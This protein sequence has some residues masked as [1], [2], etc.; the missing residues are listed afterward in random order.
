MPSL[1]KIII[2]SLFNWLLNYRVNYID[3]YKAIIDEIKLFKPDYNDSVV[4]YILTHETFV[5][6]YEYTRVHKQLQL[7]KCR[8]ENSAY[9]Q[10]LEPFNLPWYIIIHNALKTL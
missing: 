4:E 10:Y 9:S 5:C 3:S 2:Y 6:R 1:L 7:L 8:Q